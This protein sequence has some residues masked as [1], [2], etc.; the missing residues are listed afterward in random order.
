MLQPAIIYALPVLCLLAIQPTICSAL[1]CLAILQ[2]TILCALLCLPKSPL[3][4]LSI[5]QPT[6]RCAV[7]ALIYLAILQLTIYCALLCLS[8]LPSLQRTIRSAPRQRRPILQPTF[9]CALLHSVC[10][11]YSRLS[12]LLRD[13]DGIVSDL[14]CDTTTDYLLCFSA[15]SLIA[16]A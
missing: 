6:I 1:L 15:P 10:H 3:L 11:H 16:N 12:A 2:P 8:Y 14:S 9:L 5:L 13:C 7:S 4:C